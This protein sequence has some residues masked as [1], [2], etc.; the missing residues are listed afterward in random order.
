LFEEPAGLLPKFQLPAQF[1]AADT[2]FAGR[3]IIND[4]KRLQKWK[5]APV[6]QG[7]G[8]R[9]FQTSTFGALPVILF[10]TLTIVAVTALFALI[11]ILPLQGGQIFHTAFLIGKPLLKF[12]QRQ[13]L[14]PFFHNILLSL[15]IYL[16]FSY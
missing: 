16:L 13:T 12:E 5:L 1:R 9:G 14:K 4:V 7:S 3:H 6:E 8:L 2:A 15:L 10:N 11:P